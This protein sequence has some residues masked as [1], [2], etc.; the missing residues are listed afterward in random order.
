MKGGS[1]KSGSDTSNVTNA[2][3]TSGYPFPSSS[4]LIVDRP[5]QRYRKETG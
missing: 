4:T 1:T 2:G 5:E 3:G